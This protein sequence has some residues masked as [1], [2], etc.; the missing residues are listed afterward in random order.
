MLWRIA[1]LALVGVLVWWNP[2]QETVAPPRAAPPEPPAAA[3]SENQIQDRSAQC[4][5]TS[6]DEFHR[7][8]KSVA[9][10][11]AEEKP[12]AEYVYHYNARLDT[13]FLLLAVHGPEMLDLR[14]YD[15]LERELYGQ[16]LGP[17]VD[18]SPMR[19]GPAQCRVAHY[20]CGSRREWE[21]LVRNF[22]G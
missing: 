9:A 5:Q 19:A 11:P 3:L 18:E 14:L 7:G 15:V 1:L 20:H 8:W 21:A 13:C 12:P 22:M 10:G 6:S 2:H 4:A 16:Y 17:A